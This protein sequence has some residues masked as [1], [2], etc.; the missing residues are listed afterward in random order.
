VEKS[1]SVT[2][3]REL[4]HS[5]GMHPTARSACLSQAQPIKK[6]HRGRARLIVPIG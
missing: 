4:V 5:F 1:I 2:V 3:S 6:L